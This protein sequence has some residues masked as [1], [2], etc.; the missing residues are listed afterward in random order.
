LGRFGDVGFAARNTGVGGA[1]TFN[2]AR[3][4]WKRLSMEEGI[5]I[6]ESDGHDAKTRDFRRDSFE[7]ASNVTVERDWHPE[8]HSTPSISTAAGMQTEESDE[9]PRNDFVCM[10]ISLELV[11][12]VT[13]DMDGHSLK[14]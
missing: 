6:D 10:Q 4:P 3:F 5:T 14:Q 9:Q 11:S 1:I 7:P 12:K 8:K 13:A 2:I